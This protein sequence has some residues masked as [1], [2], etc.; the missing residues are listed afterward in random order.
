M[1]YTL[2]R[3]QDVSIISSFQR[4]RWVPL[5]A[6]SQVSYL[7][8]FRIHDRI[9]AERV[10]GGMGVDRKELLGAMGEL[11]QYQF[12]L[13]RSDATIVKVLRREQ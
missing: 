9:D 2:V 10:A 6:V 7:I 12:I 5:E 4:P 1:L 11:E 13:I 3:S 8:C